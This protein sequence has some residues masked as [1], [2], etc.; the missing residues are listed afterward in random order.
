VCASLP[1]A[2]ARPD[3]IAQWMLARASFAPPRLGASIHWHGCPALRS[4][5]HCSFAPVPLGVVLALTGARGRKR[6]RDQKFVEQT[7]RAATFIDKLTHRKLSSASLAAT[8]FAEP[9]SGSMVA[10]AV[11]TKK[12][13]NPYLW[14]EFHQQ[15]Y[16][17]VWRRHC[18]QSLHSAQWLRW[19]R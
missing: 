1:R 8:L 14:C 7:L 5:W 19:R 16:S 17:A 15:P 4:I 13:P 2:S 12:L 10:I 9:T 18:L 6:R 11:R 3:I